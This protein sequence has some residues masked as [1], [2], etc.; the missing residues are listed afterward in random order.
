M[1]VCKK[2]SIIGFGCKPIRTIRHNQCKYIS[3]VTAKSLVVR[4]IRVA[5]NPRFLA[6]TSYHH[7]YDTAVQP[8]SIAFVV[9]LPLIVSLD[10]LQTDLRLGDAAPT[11]EQVL[12][13]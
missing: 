11:R 7:F 10:F 5:N 12:N 1:T 9:L 8:F 4:C 2:L 3:L 6:S 13:S